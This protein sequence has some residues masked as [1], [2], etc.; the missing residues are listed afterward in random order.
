VFAG[1]RGLGRGGSGDNVGERG[2]HAHLFG[3]R[4]GGFGGRDETRYCFGTGW[5]PSP[6]F[7]EVLT[8]GQDGGVTYY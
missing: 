7:Q 4:A 1:P 3:G 6:V 8:A 5:F 2:C